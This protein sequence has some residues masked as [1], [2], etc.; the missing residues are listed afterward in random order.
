[1]NNPFKKIADNAKETSKKWENYKN[2][3]TLHTVACPRCGAPRP[4]NTNV[5][6]CDYCHYKFMNIEV[7]V[8]RKP[9][10]R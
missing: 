5:G 7:M 3:P 8:S 2:A 6:T 9:G 4:V 1:M 10:E